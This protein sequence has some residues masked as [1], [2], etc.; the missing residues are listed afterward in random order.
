MT[1]TL[2]SAATATGAGSAVERTGSAATF[3]AYGST[4]AG[5][6]ASAIAVQA[7][8]VATPGTNDWLTIGTITLV[9][10][11][12]STSDGFAIDAPWRHIRGNV[13]SISGTNAAVTLLMRG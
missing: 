7:S 10:G 11:T 2:I 1:I 4:S 3:Q 12:T 9:L 5:A 13:L 6:G 8:N